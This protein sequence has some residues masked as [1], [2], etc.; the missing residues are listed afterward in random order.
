[1]FPKHSRYVTRG[2]I[3]TIGPD[4]QSA[5]WSIIDRDLNEGKEMDYLQ[6]FSLSIVHAGGQVYQRIRH[7][8][9]KPERK[10]TYDL[11]GIREPVSG[12]TVWIIDS[13]TYCTM[14]LPEEY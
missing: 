2:V 11:S 7:R 3:E 4:I 12:V 5:L 9:E 10:R 6:V 1:M 8:Q 13:G 14:L